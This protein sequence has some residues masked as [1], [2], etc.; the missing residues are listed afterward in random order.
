[1]QV[2]IAPPDQITKFRDIIDV[3][4]PSEFAI[5]HIPGAINCPVLNDDERARVGTLHKTNPFE[6][7]KLGAALISANMGRLLQTTFAEH[8]KSWQPLVYCW[9]GGLR[10]GSVAII[11]TQIGWR[12]HQLQGGYKAYRHRVLDQLEDLP[13]RLNFIVLCGPTGSGK[14]RFLQALEC[15]GEQVLDLETLAVHR[16]S[17]L[18]LVPGQVQPSQRYFETCLWEKLHQFD[19]TRPVFI[20]SESRRIGQMSLPSSLY[21]KMHAGK[22]LTLEVPLSE[23][24]RFLC[25]DYDFYLQNPQLLIDKLDA[26]KAFRS[27]QELGRWTEMAQTGNFYM[28]V[29]ELLEIHYDPLYWRSLRSH[30]PQAE[31]GDHLTLESLA[32]E[33]LLEAVMAYSQK[34]SLDK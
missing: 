15:C 17:I 10:S 19:P 28:L 2:Q 13:T 8:K 5:D 20:E 22:C 11:M 34:Q 32:P 25:E 31:E 30:Y 21:Q 14:S 6:A 23:R 16:G 26:L 7:R 29:N 33:S 4:S 27:K 12:V 24:I 3:R 18:G 1:M 9:R